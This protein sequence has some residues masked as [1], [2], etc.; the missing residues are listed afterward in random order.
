MTS[1]TVHPQIAGRNHFLKHFQSSLTPSTTVGTVIGHYCGNGEDIPRPIASSKEGVIIRFLSDAS[2]SGNGFRLEWVVDGCGGIM[3][4]PTGSIM[5]PNYPNV[6]PGKKNCI[7][8][9]LFFLYFL[10]VLLIMSV[11]FLWIKV[12]FEPQAG[13]RWKLTLRL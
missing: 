8:I 9:H 5:S 3:R 12:I 13:L 10:K 4:K 1:F 11:I 2:V 7:Q 6:Y